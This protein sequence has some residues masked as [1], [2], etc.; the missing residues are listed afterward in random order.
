MTKKKIRYEDIESM[1]IRVSRT[2]NFIFGNK[3]KKYTSLTDTLKSYQKTP[4]IDANEANKVV[5]P[6]KLEGEE[7]SCNDIFSKPATNNEN[8][9]SISRILRYKIVFGKSIRKIYLNLTG[10]NP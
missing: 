2:Y 5:K 7:I 6:H 3:I 10:F 1:R 8:T 9:E 4:V